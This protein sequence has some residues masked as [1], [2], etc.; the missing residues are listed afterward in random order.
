M[1]H[2]KVES[3]INWPIPKT[4]GDVKRF[5]GLATF[6]R[7]FI[8]SSGQICAPGLDTIKGGKKTFFSWIEE[9][10]DAFDYLKSRVAQ[11]PIL[12]IP[13]FKKLFTIEMDANN[14]TIGE[15]LSQEG[16]PM[17]IF[18]EK[19]NEAKNKYSTYDLELYDMVQALNK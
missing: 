1:D 16:R 8:K 19:F 5:H 10:N 17:A 14:L 11:F 12:F 7:K 13:D 4:S 9:A 18:L 6:Y 15:V 2:S 3:I